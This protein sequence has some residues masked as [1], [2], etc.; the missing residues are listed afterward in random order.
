VRIAL[1]KPDDSTK[2]KQSIRQ[3]WE[4]VA[5]EYTKD[6]LGIFEQSAG[7]LLELLDSPTG[8]SILDVGCGSGAI[9]LQATSWVGSEGLVIGSDIA[10]TMLHMGH[11][12]AEDERSDIKFCQMDA[13][14]LGFN[15][16]S[17]E[18]VTCAFS[19]FQFNDMEQALNEMWRVLKPGGRLGLSNWGRGFFSPIAS[20]QRD[21]FR[22][23]KIRPLLNNPLTFKPGQLNDLL[24]RTNF[25]EVEIVEETVE[26]WFTT[27]EQVW[28]FNTDMGPFPIMLRQQLSVDQQRRLFHEFKAAMG[29]LVTERGIKSTFHLIYALARKGDVD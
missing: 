18:S 28:A 10:V 27:P 5:V 1:I 19:L 4:E 3:G 20:I 7:R 29:D 6:R 9:P 26:V 12:K 2:V 11:A 16:A 15:N 23:F 25:S 24:T 8:S 14:Q 21:I 17:F 22:M 13:E